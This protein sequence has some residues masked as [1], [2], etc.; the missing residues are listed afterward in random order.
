MKQQMTK[1]SGNIV[2]FNDWMCNQRGQ[3]HAGREEYQKYVQ[4]EGVNASRLL[5]HA[6]D[7]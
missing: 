2:E 4:V 1:M 3:L 7:G 5:V 6:L